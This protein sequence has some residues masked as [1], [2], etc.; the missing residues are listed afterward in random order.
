M[1]LGT[2]G[3]RTGALRLVAFRLSPESAARHRLRRSLQHHLPAGSARALR[4]FDELSSVAAPP[5]V[6]AAGAMLSAPGGL[7][8]DPG[9]RAA[10]ELAFGPAIARTAALLQLRVCAAGKELAAGDAA[11][12]EAL[13][14]AGVPFANV[15]VAIDCTLSNNDQ[16]ANC[17]MKETGK[18]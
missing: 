6:A 16:G 11:F 1:F 12:K 4:I 9:A 2:A 10:L 14:R 18:G 15:I 5:A 3:H 8:A 7:P 13:A 17:S